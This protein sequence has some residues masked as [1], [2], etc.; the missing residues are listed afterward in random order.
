MLG[1]VNLKQYNHDSSQHLDI[2][3]NNSYLY[4][5]RHLHYLVCCSLTF[6]CYSYVII[7]VDPLQV[8]TGRISSGLHYTPYIN[9][10]RVS[11]PTEVHKNKS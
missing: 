11:L 6:L 5:Y 10:Y 9:M 1:G 7:Y 8:R 2:F 4:N 3:I